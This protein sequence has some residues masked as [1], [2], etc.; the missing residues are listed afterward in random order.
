M[1]K[2]EKLELGQSVED[3]AQ[4]LEGHP[5]YRVLRRLVPRQDFGVVEHGPTVTVAILDVETTGMD[6]RHDRIIELAMILVEV[7]PGSGR[8]VR[9]LEE[10][11]GFE[12]PGAHIDAQITRLTGI[13][14]AMVQGK[15]LDEEGVAA[16]LARSTLV[17]AHNARFDRAFME[18]RFPEFANVAWACSCTEI[19]W[20]AEDFSSA[21]LSSL[22]MGYGWF[23]D[24][25]RALVD[26]HAVLAVIDHR[27][28]VSQGTGLGRLLAVAREGSYRVRA[29]AA[30]FEVK[31]TLKARGYRWD[32]EARVWHTLVRG[33]GPLAAERAWLKEKIYGGK[34]ATIAVEELDAKVR[35]SVRS[36]RPDAVRL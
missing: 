17:I 14:D 36:G 28:P 30:P 32:A 5:D 25:H 16:L 4:A 34:G 21:K 29:T 20:S 2:Q 8:A 22:A 23:F 1:G 24:G 18:N 9:V 35:F 27:L 15:K 10:Y 6:P 31:D 13:D 33:E 11:E 12:D 19:D 26:C 3:M 7:D